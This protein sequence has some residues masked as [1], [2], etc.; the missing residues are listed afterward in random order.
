MLKKRGQFGKMNGVRSTT[1]LVFTNSG[2]ESGGG[3]KVDFIFIE[4]L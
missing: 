3:Y 1:S 2:M 4:G